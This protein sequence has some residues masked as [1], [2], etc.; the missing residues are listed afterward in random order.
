MYVTIAATKYADCPEYRGAELKV[1]AVRALV[2][3]AMER[4]RVLETLA[5]SIRSLAAPACHDRLHLL[6]G[7]LSME[8][9]QW[10]N[11]GETPSV[12]DGRDLMQY[13]SDIQDRIDEEDWSHE[14]DR[15]LAVYLDN[16]LLKQRVV[17]MFPGIHVH[18][19]LNKPVQVVD[20]A[21]LQDMVDI[22]LRTVHAFRTQPVVHQVPS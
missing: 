11:M 10:G 12:L 17:S 16:Q 13:A 14:G 4:A 8:E 6:R 22:L 19:L 15:G 7:Q 3:D 2:Q 9:D 20:L 21:V 5:P 1:P 18:K